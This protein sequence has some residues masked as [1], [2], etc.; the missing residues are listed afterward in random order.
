MHGHTHSRTH[1]HMH[2]HAPTRINKHSNKTHT[3]LARCIISLSY[4][5]AAASESW[6]SQ[7]RRE[8]GN[9]ANAGCAGE[10]LEAKKGKNDDSLVL[11]Q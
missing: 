7:L 6:A 3:A 11:L 4:Y 10:G 8:L 5:K 1:A 2:T 9:P